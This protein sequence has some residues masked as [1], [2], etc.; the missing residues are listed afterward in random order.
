MTDE[1]T[2][3]HRQA[4]RDHPG[5][6]RP[7]FNADL[8]VVPT[9]NAFTGPLLITLVAVPFAAI[10]MIVLTH[11]GWEPWLAGAVAGLIIGA[12]QA[13][14]IWKGRT[15]RAQDGSRPPDSHLS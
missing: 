14:W 3:S 8:V 10:A 12:W 15:G 5:H 2:R 9:M 11:Q 6:S 13:I 7:A 1:E 4:G